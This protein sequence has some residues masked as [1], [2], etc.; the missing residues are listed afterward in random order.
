[1][2][3]PE[4]ALSLAEGMKTEWSD[5]DGVAAVAHNRPGAILRALRQVEVQR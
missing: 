1:M 4:D 5:S 3:I 2:K